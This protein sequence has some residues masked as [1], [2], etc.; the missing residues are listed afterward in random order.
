MRRLILLAFVLALGFHKKT[1][2]PHVNTPH[3]ANG[4]RPKDGGADADGKR[5]K[6]SG[7]DTDPARRSRH[8]TGATVRARQASL[9]K[10]ATG[11]TARPKAP[12]APKGPDRLPA[13]RTRK[14]AKGKD[15]TLDP[16]RVK[17]AP[18]YTRGFAQD[19]PKPVKDPKTGKWTVTLRMHE[20]WDRSDF[21][22]KANHLKNLGDEGKLVKT[23]DTADLR[24]DKTDAWRAGKEREAFEQATDQADLDRRLAELDGQ[25]V[26][27]AQD[28][29]LGGKDSPDNMWAIDS[30]TNHGMGGQLRQQLAQ[31][32]NG[33][34]VQINI[35]HDKY[36][37]KP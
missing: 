8:A 9:K 1:R 4:K 27:H 29:Q 16:D 15:I 19:L 33:E 5:R 6:G 18:T 21:E 2:A 30:A 20:G 36:S 7:A 37:P 12:G 23:P 17:K 35:V 31:A 26:D 25:Q 13:G 22:A 34:P 10:V 11:T 3:G 32:P 14:D 24:S 28:L